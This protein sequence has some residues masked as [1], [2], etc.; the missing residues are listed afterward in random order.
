MQISKISIVFIG[1]ALGSV[2]RY[3]VSVLVGSILSNI[4]IIF[5]ATLIVNLAGC[6]LIG[7]LI[8]NTNIT[9]RL[10]LLLITG[11]CGGFTTFSSFS[12]ES[13]IMIQYG[14]LILALLYIVGS[15]L[16]GTLFLWYGYIISSKKKHSET[17]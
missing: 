7:L 16:F 17:F 15:I 5:L 9:K 13:L 10:N 8:G 3:L 12:K 6:F 2:F 4:S 14:E 11:F 1:G